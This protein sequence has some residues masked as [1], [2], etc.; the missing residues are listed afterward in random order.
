MAI[1]WL[2]QGSPKAP[3]RLHQ[4]FTKAPHE[5]PETAK[6]EDRRFQISE[7]EVWDMREESLGIEWG[8]RVES[9]EK[10]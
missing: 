4:G 5:R 3:P 8:L 1:I 6:M 10:A 9:V 7:S 2:P